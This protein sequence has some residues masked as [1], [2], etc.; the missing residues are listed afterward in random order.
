[1]IA[2]IDF[3]GVETVGAR[4]ARGVAML[5]REVPGWHDR[6]V[7]ETLNLEICYHCVFGQLFIGNYAEGEAVMFSDYGNPSE[8]SAAHGFTL[9]DQDPDDDS[10]EKLWHTLTEEW[11]KVITARQNA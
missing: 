5:D 3:Y 4:V 1:M 11:I 10:E 6:I 2:Q 8:A 7:T 9:G